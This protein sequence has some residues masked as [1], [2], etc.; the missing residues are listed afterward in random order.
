M[1]KTW[2]LAYMTYSS[3]SLKQ[4]ENCGV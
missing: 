1:L 4:A 3:G 2:S